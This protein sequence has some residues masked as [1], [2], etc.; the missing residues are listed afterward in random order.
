MSL[1]NT[2]ATLIE[3]AERKGEAVKKVRELSIMGNAYWGVSKEAVKNSPMVN[4]W[5]V[6]VDG[7]IVVVVEHYDTEIFKANV[8]TKELLHWYGESNSDRDALNGLC[9]NYRLK[10][11]F[12]YRPSKDLFERI[13]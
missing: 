8:S 3:R 10:E 5:K 6:V 2:L 7:D 4:Q 9:A 13:I 11:R 1:T 12:S